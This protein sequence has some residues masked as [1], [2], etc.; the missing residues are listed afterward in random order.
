[1]RNVHFVPA[2]APGQNLAGLASLVFTCEANGIN[3]EAYLADVLLRLGSHPASLLD[4]LLPHR[5][6]PAPADAS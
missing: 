4:E 3:P 5:W 6:S 2:P 1:M